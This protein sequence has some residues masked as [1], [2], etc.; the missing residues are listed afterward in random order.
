MRCPKP[1]SASASDAAFEEQVAALEAQMARTRSAK[2][3]AHY[4]NQ[5]CA[6]IAAWNLHSLIVEIREEL[7]R[8]R[9]TEHRRR[10]AEIDTLLEAIVNVGSNFPDEYLHKSMATRFFAVL[11]D[12][13]GCILSTTKEFHPVVFRTSLNDGWWHL[14]RAEE[15][16]Y[17]IE[18]AHET[19]SK[20]GIEHTGIAT[21]ELR[22]ALLEGTVA[23]TIEDIAENRHMSP[24][25]VLFAKAHSRRQ[26]K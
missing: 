16:A 25:N 13:A 2:K 10:E 23:G 15:V 21:K 4:E 18:R 7:S 11:C 20:G 5:G 26:A 6:V 9:M 8:G 1:G 19:G 12:A 3:Q 24:R 22:A 14:G 17:G